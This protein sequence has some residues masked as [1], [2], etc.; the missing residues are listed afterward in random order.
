MTFRKHTL[1]DGTAGYRFA[2]R[3]STLQWGKLPLFYWPYLTGN[4]KTLK[5]TVLP[6]V[7]ASYSDQ[8]GPIVRTTWDLFAVAGR[9]RPE[10]VRA[11]GRLDYLGDRGPATG[12]NLDYNLTRMFGQLDGYLLAHDTAEDQIGDRNDVAFDGE[13]RGYAL[14]RHRQQLRD[15]WQ[16]S[17]EASYVSDETFLEEFFQ[18]EA[19]LSKPY[20]T[21]IYLK[22]QGRYPGI[23]VLKPVRHKRLHSTDHNPPVTGIHG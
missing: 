21:S 14:L 7:S 5:D 23:H 19:E 11:E 20:E 1:R 8:D 15:H 17:L 13:T 12:I 22:K 9:P 6:R 16:L 4:V 2:S 18:N 10:G 3:D